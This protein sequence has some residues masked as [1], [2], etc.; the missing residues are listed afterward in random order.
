MKLSDLTN[1]W[2]CQAWAGCQAMRRRRRE[3]GSVTMENVLWA[4]AVI[5]IAAIVVAAITTFV[6]NHSNELLGP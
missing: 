6:Q 2:W 3:A 5:A 1:R 4:L